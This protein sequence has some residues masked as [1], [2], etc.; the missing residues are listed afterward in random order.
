MFDPFAD[1]DDRARAL[2]AQDRGERQPH[3]AVGQGQVGVT[4]PGGGEPDADPAGAGVRK[5]DLLI[6]K[7][8]P[9]AGSTAARTAMFG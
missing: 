1:G 4:D 5:D 3:G 9:M 7:G 6:S 2:V 8:A